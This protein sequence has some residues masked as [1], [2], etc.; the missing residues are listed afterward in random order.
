MGLFKSGFTTV[1]VISLEKLP[2]LR[3]RLTIRVTM[4]AYYI[5]LFNLMIV[6]SEKRVYIEKVIRKAAPLANIQS[7]LFAVLYHSV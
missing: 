6:Q 2:E 7:I 5:N 4:G 3:D 1:D